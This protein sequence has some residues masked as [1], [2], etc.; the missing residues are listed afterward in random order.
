MMTD[1][2]EIT[3]DAPASREAWRPAPL[4]FLAGDDFDR[5]LWSVF[6]MPVDAAGLPDAVEAIAAAARSGRPLSFVTPNV[7]FAARAA[8]SAEARRDIIAAD[9]SLV[10]GAPLVALAR[11]AGAPIRTRCA[12]SDVFA[13]LRL[14][15]GFEGRRIRVFLFGGRDGAAEQ[16][17]RRL[18]EERRGVECVGWLNPG[19]GD[20]AS[21]S[22]EATIA[23]IN[24]AAPD[25]VVVALGA[26]KGQSWISA[27]RARLN[28]PVVAH[29]GA[30]VDFVAGGK[31]RAPAF[32][33]R[34]GLEWAW[35]IKEEPSLWRRYFRDAGAMARI[36]AARAPAIVAERLRRPA[37]PGALALI[38]EGGRM[39]L[40]VTGDLA[41]SLSREARAV[42]RAAAAA[43]LPVL[44][45]LR[46]AGALGSSFFGLLMALEKNLAAAGAGLA[47][48][49]AAPSRQRLFAAHGLAYQVAPDEALLED[50]G[51]VIAGAA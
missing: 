5:D 12:G 30:V 33:A 36:V 43:R 38:P 48:Y 6:G 24:A 28:A 19:H 23:A 50:D 37:A 1:T 32:V 39:R 7:N 34:A 51:V 14:R 27:N 18:N 42:L 10:D 44:I 22:G 47:L 40:V 2:A 25:F 16:A 11:L 49:G 9:Y 26:A 21:M 45:D 29:L 4:A 35:R 46:R 13:A 15:P 3:A 41:Q 31:A 8:A 17:A 20:V